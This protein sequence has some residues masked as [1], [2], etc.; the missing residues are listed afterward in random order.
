M[1]TYNYKRKKNFPTEFSKD[2]QFSTPIWHAYEPSFVSS[3]NKASDPYIEAAKKRMAPEIKRRNKTYGNKED[4]GVVYHST[5]L[6]QDSKFEKLNLYVIQTSAR[7]LADMGYDLKNYAV[8][9][10]EMWVQEFPKHG[11]GLHTPHTHWNGHVSGFYFLKSDEE[12]TTRPVFHDP[13]PG[14]EMIGL[15]ELDTS[16]ITPSSHEI[17]YSCKPGTVFFFPSYLTHEFPLDLGYE[18]FR[19]IHWNC[20]AV[21]KKILDGYA[22]NI[23]LNFKL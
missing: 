9:C 3:L 7:L 5:T 11:G 20:Q 10:T 4:T 6:S 1:K 12:K 13:R 8:F 22:N 14:K 19:F 2:N 15:P 23:P 16:I 17:N 21:D 18:P